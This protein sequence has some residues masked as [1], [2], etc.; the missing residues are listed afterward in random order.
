MVETPSTIDDRARAAAPQGGGRVGNIVQS[1]PKV[2]LEF[3]VF[4]DG[5]L[6]NGPNSRRTGGEGSY[7]NAPS[8]V[9][10]L[11]QIY[12]NNRDLDTRNSCGGY[13]RRIRSLYVAGIGTVTGGEDSLW[14]AGLGYGATGVEQRVIDAAL[15][16]GGL[17]TQ[18]SPGVEPK[19]IIMDVFG[20]SRGAAAARYFVNCFRQGYI[21]A[22]NAFNSGGTLPPGRKVRFRFIGLFD[23]VAAIGYGR[24]DWNAPINVHL[25]AAQATRIYH[26]TAQHEYRQNFRLNH[27]LPG[28][29][30]ARGL[31]GAHSDIGGGYRDVGDEVDIASTGSPSYSS[32]VAAE[33]ARSRMVAEY[34]AQRTRNEA[35]WVREGWINANEPVGGAV[36]KVGPVVQT[37]RPTVAGIAVPTYSFEARRVLS[38]PWVQPGLSRIPLRIIYNEAVAQAVP[39]LSLPTTGPYAVPAGLSSAAATLVG[40]GSLGA[41]ETRSVLRNYGH[42]SANVGATGMAAEPNH[43]RVIYPN[44]TSRA[45]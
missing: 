40:G 9:Y 14:G 23:T 42:V 36:M 3:G 20:F 43:V 18:L 2:T 25:K 6:N 5:T 31:P 44:D 27:N 35:I 45:K 30:A 19:E 22:R 7:A 1:C 24:N 16:I 21:D 15:Q 29:G 10:L 4:F 38:R 41:V 26:L 33:A 13:L 12:K 17:I 34:A 32:R 39:F 28:G 11:S 37:M 8:N